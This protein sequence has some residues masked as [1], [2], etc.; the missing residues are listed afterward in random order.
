VSQ[1]T[2]SERVTRVQQLLAELHKMPPEKHETVHMPWTAGEPL[3]EVIRIGV[4]EV[5]L[6]PP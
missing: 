4:D 1:I 5:L 2:E 3:L 6:N